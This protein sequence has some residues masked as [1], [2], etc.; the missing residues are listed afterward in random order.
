MTFELNRRQ[1][2]LAGA[3][4][5]VAG[6]ALAQQTYTVDMLNKDPD[7]KKRRMIFKPLI[8]VVEAGDTVRFASVHKGHNSESIKGMI[9]E[10]V[11]P[12]KSKISKDFDLTLTV[13]GVYGYKC[14]PHTAMGM[15]G[16]IIVKGDG[17]MANVEAA[18]AVKH[19]GRMKKVWEEMWA[20]VEAEGLLQG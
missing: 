7:D 16:L 11:E 17:M 14:T 20:Q 2:I 6:P 18:K 4:M 8:Q 19:K 3:A 12:W 15:A 13:P 1:I 9:P 10:G 5:L